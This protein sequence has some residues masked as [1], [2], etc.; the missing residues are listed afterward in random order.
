[1]KLNQT[2]MNKLFDLMMMT[3]KFQIMRIKYPEEIYQLT[4]NHLNML[5]EILSKDPTHNNDIMELVKEN[6]EY[7]QKVI[8]F[9]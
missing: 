7:F 2:S 8:L 3:F 9:N 1:M 4:M 5:L 6:I